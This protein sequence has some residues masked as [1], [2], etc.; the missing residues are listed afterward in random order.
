MIDR[1]GML[2][3]LT[4]GLAVMSLGTPKALAI[5][6]SKTMAAMPSLRVL[7]AEL[8][9]A[10]DHRWEMQKPLL[11]VRLNRPAP[12]TDAEIAAYKQAY[13]EMLAAAE[14]FMG[15]PSDNR[16]DVLLKYGMLEELLYEIRGV[17]NHAVIRRFNI[18]L[19]GIEQEE[20]RLQAGIHFWWRDG[21]TG[22]LP[23]IDDQPVWWRDGRWEPLRRSA[24][25]G[26]DLRFSILMKKDA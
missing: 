25:A 9:A 13:A 22:G 1:R 19:Y 3:A 11:W 23:L 8:S 6:A 4:S 7:R 20:R 24:R 18:W 21:A 5:A 17:E 12:A 10:M 15:R 26:K 14:R 16:D 2:L